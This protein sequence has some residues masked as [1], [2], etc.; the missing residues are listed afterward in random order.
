MAKN[1][2]FMVIKLQKTYINMLSTSFMADNQY[3]PNFINTVFIKCKVNKIFLKKLLKTVKKHA[4]KACG[5]STY[6]L[7]GPSVPMLHW[8]R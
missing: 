3:Y 2:L 1:L 8:H 6:S 4:Y 5:L 7:S